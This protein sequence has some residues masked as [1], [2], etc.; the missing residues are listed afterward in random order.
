MSLLTV[1]IAVLLVLLVLAVIGGVLFFYIYWWRMQRPAPQLDGTVIVQGL[2][3]PVE[4]VRDKHGIPH[5]FA[6]TEAD[7][8][9]TLGYVHAQDRFWQMEQMRRTAQGRLAEI[10][11][12][13][14]LDADRFC[15][16]VGL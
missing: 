15:R 5:I 9:R 6:E 3:R 7:L 4:V 11:G 8:Y 14:A 1:V 10:F 16:I 13:A 12:E 2:D